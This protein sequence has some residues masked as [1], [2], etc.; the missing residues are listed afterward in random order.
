MNEKRRKSK[1]RDTNNKNTEE[2]NTQEKLFY[3][4]EHFRSL[5]YMW[6]AQVNFFIF[7]LVL[8]LWLHNDCFC[9]RIRQNYSQ[10][11]KCE[12]NKNKWNEFISRCDC[13]INVKN[14]QKKSN[15]KDIEMTAESKWYRLSNL[16]IRPKKKTNNSTNETREWISYWIVKCEK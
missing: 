16:N 8:I 4:N 15:G 3:F 1:S 9:R 10:K 2:M 12:M 11:V 14:N 6:M 13:E 5:V 7:V